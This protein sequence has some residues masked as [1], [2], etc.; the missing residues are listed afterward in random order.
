MKLPAWSGT[1]L[2]MRASLVFV[3][4]LLGCHGQPLVGAFEPLSAPDIVDCGRAFVGGATGC[5]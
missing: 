2:G 4:A 5:S 3:A 1:C